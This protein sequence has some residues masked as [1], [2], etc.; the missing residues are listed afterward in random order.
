MYIVTSPSTASLAVAPSSV[1]E[2]PT[3]RFTVDAPL[4]VITGGVTSGDEST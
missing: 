2:L 4:R 3:K 1:Y